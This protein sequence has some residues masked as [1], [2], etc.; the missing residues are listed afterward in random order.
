MAVTAY[1]T[2]PN[3]EG[4][5]TASGF[6]GEIEV[7]GFDWGL[8]GAQ[9]SGSRRSKPEIEPLTVL[10][11]L[12]K[13]SVYIAQAAARGMAFQEVV[14]RVVTHVQGAPAEYLKYTLKKAVITRYEIENAGEDAPDD[15]LREMVEITFS[16]AEL[17]FVENPGLPNP[18]EHEVGI[19]VG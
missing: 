12:D 9:M 8:R 4:G 13:A 18:S 14:F 19:D 16:E 17:L 3:I 2:I 15:V 10:K 11:R 7:Q 5:S 1:L 6:E